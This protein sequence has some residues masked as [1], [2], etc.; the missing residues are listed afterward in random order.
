[1][2]GLDALGAGLDSFVKHRNPGN[3]DR[4][5]VLVPENRNS[6]PLQIGVLF[7]FNRGVIVTAQ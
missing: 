4:H 2:R 7:L 1:M 3:A 6:N 5:V